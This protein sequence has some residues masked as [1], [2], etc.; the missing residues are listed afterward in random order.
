MSENV[1]YEVLAR[2]S[3]VIKHHR[4]TISHHNQGYDL[5]LVT[6][7]RSLLL[8]VKKVEGSVLGLPPLV[9]GDEKEADLTDLELVQSFMNANPPLR[10]LSLAIG[11]HSTCLI[12]G[13]NSLASSSLATRISRKLNLNRP[14]YVVS[15]IQIAADD[16]DAA[17]L[18][19]NLYLKIFQ[20]VKANYDASHSI[21]SS[22]VA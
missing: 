13:E 10:G 3:A 19:P 2:P 22:A 18:M 11:E 7:K 12:P 9:D 8:V 21:D 14:I 16:L 20:F 15:E 1:S 6:M 17:D 4:K 5:L